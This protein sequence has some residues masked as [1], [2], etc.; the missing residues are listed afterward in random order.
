[1][2]NKTG[3][4]VDQDPD[5]V[6]ISIS[7]RGFLYFFSTIGWLGLLALIGAMFSALYCSGIIKVFRRIAVEGRVPLIVPG[8]RQNRNYILRTNLFA[9]YPPVQVDLCF[10]GDSILAYPSWHEYFRSITVAVRAIE[11]DRTIGVI[12]RLDRIVELSPSVVVLQVGIN[13]IL[14]GETPSVVAGRILT[15]IS[16]LLA[17]RI[18]CCLIGVFPV[19]PEREGFKLVNNAVHEVNQYLR[20]AVTKFNV[21]FLD[22]SPVLAPDGYLK[23]CHTYDGIHLTAEG[24]TIIVQELKITLTSLKFLPTG[25]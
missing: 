17:N 14:T 15:V 5:N 9:T 11:G 13:D 10:V 20:D 16:I 7:R 24:Y 1:M 25:L 19:S 21:S 8:Y 23:L 4:A 2:I 3:R 22:L 6:N 12:S 18:D